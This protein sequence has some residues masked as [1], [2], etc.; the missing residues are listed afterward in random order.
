MSFSSIL[1]PLEFLALEDWPIAQSKRSDPLEYLSVERLN[2]RLGLEMQLSFQTLELPPRIIS[3]EP[4]LL[5]HL[6]LGLP[7]EI[8]D[9]IWFYTYPLPLIVGKKGNHRHVHEEERR[10][11]ATSSSRPYCTSRAS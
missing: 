11:P 3:P 5:F 7:T 2:Y 1:K 8:K 6:F 4:L 9:R 10:L